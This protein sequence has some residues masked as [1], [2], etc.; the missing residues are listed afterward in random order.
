MQAQHQSSGGTKATTTPEQS[1]QATRHLLTIR[2]V[3]TALFEYQVRKTPDAR[4]RLESLA[5]FAMAQGD[6]TEIEALV[7]AN[8][9]AIPTKSIQQQGRNHV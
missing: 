3:G 2:I 4:V 8:V 7:V 1:A 9:L 5:T 6:L